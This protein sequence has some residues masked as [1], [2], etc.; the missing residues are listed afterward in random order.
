MMVRL[1]GILCAL[2]SLSA[3]ADVPRP[4]PDRGD[5]FVLDLGIWDQPQWRV[6]EDV[7]DAARM[8]A[9][10][11]L[12]PL[13]LCQED[14]TASQVEWC[15]EHR[16]RARELAEELKLLGVSHSYFPFL[17]L[18]DGAWRGEAEPANW[19]QWMASYQARLDEVM[20]LHNKTGGAEFILGT[21]LSR[22]YLA[23]PAEWSAALKKYRAQTTTPVLTVA[24]WDQFDKIP[25]WGDSDV[26]GL[27]SYYPLSS[28]QGDAAGSVDQLVAGWA[29]WKKSLTDVA[30][31]A[32]RPLYFAEVG[33][34]SVPG[35]AST[36]WDY[37][38]TMTAPPDQDLQARLFEAFGRAWA[39]EPTLGR[40]MVWGM[41]HPE[42]PADDRGYT[43]FDK[44]AQGRLSQV[45]H[46][47]A[48]GEMVLPAPP[49][50]DV[51]L[52]LDDF[53]MWFVDDV[54]ERIDAYSRYRRTLERRHVPT[55]A[56]LNAAG[57]TDPATDPR[58]VE[59]LGAWRDSGVVFANH[60]AHH[61]A[62]DSGADA[63][64]RDVD[65]GAHLLDGYFA[66]WD[67]PSR[68]FRFP[69][70]S[71]GSDPE[72]ACQG[73]KARGYSSLPIAYFSG[74][75]AIAP[76]YH[77]VS[78]ATLEDRPGGG[79]DA[80]KVA[81]EFMAEASRQ[82]GYAQARFRPYLENGPDHSALV[83]LMHSTRMTRDYLDA[84]LWMLERQGARWVAA[85]PQNLTAY[86]PKPG[87]CLPRCKEDGSC[88]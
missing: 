4:L 65:Q 57:L 5:G 16:E 69:N 75:H 68:L 61:L 25:F 37:A 67:S 31:R 23:H 24:N 3:W 77:P 6:L 9:R 79:D 88:F 60:T 55:V 45:F 41:Y 28:G 44:P 63:F 47:R 54:G 32:G 42:V 29:P 70:G 78:A 2:A 33:Y 20:E 86:T 7:T 52:T 40:F 73:L 27:S 48:S 35:A 18:N 81:R 14:R 30:K 26:I 62:I 34:A 85:T 19:A 66:G 8:G 36:P 39:Q 71:W 51:L 80:R 83:M 21:E 1:L 72:A 82:F 58:E 15:F 10:Q 76:D 46:D 17:L 74:D 43:V 38:S 53:P 13:M 50:V 22:I 64:W 49:P 84:T 12:I 11:V 56:F 59:A 87:K